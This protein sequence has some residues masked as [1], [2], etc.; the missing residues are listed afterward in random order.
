MWFPVT[1]SLITVSGGRPRLWT[2]RHGSTDYVAAFFRI[3]HAFPVNLENICN[4]DS[5][6]Q[7]FQIISTLTTF[8]YRTVITTFKSLYVTDTIYVNLN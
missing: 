4:M 6:F 2:Q 3:P 5:S 8:G 1:Q 7:F